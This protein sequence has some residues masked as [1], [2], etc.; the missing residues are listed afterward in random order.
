M[1]RNGE[2]QWLC[3]S[4]HPVLATACGILSTLVAENWEGVDL[5]IK[6]CF[7]YLQGAKD[8]CLVKRK[9]VR[10]GLKTSSDAD[11]AGLYAVL[12]EKRSRTG[13]LAEYDNMPVAWKSSWQQ[14]KGTEF[15]EDADIATSSA[16]AETYAAA[17]AAKLSIHLK[18]I[19]EEIDIA[20]SKPVIIAIDAGAA[21]GFINNTGSIGR[22]K[23][24][25]LHESWV[26]Q[27]RDRQQV[28]FKKVPGTENPADFF[29]KII[30]GPE[31]KKHQGS[32]MGTLR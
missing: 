2:L 16:E 4:T 10:T 6:H 26:S 9:G 29:T 31:F 12:G 13:I 8:L 14:C 32:L 15:S 22:M 3:Q 28:S 1:A 19:C 21:L 24:I 20:V 18:N 27:M 30:T 11:W 5:A 7:R 23:H 17:D 25:D